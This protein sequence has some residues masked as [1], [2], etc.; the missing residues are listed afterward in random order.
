MGMKYGLEELTKCHSF[1]LI[2]PFGAGVGVLVPK[3][4]SFTI[5]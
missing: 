1:T 3:A 4:D 2:L 5:Y